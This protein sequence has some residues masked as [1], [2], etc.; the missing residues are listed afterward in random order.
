M[1]FKIPQNEFIIKFMEALNLTSKYSKP[2]IK[3][4]EELVVIQKL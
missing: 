4:I 3:H 2:A 1:E